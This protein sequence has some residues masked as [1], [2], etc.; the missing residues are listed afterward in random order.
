LLSSRGVKSIF[1]DHLH[2]TEVISKFTYQ[3]ALLKLSKTWRTKLI[4][5]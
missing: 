4:R 1:D 3:I 2:Y 5:K